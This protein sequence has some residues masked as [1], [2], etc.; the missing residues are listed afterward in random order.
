MKTVL[1]TRTASDNFINHIKILNFNPII[2]PTIET[3]PINFN[4]KINLHEF[5]III[6]ISPAA[7]TH[8]SNQ[9]KT[10]PADLKIFTMG[11]DSAGLVKS[12]GWNPPTYPLKNYSRNGLLDLPEL[13]NVSDISV[14]IIEAQNSNNILA[15]ELTSR[16]AHVT[17][18]F[19]YEKVLP[20][21][22]TYPNLENIDIIIATSETGLNNL[23]TLL[24]PDVKHKTLLLS[25]E[26][27]V[28]VAKKAGFTQKPLLAQNASE[29]ALLQALKTVA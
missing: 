25:S 11:E 1:I 15:A 13:Q 23:V 3:K 22:A 14:L 4:A 21:P 16:G 5:K 7:I 24:G 18:L 29:N 17:Q 19:A 10:L 8:F 9:I 12:L 2:F 28:S 26:R 20:K 27:L 6:F